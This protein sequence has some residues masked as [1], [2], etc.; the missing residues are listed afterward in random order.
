M[1]Q[2]EHRKRGAAKLLFFI[3]ALE[4]LPI[5]LPLHAVL[6]GVFFVEGFDA[7]VEALLFAQD[8]RFKTGLRKAS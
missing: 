2:F 4:R 6:A 3:S 1:T 8:G 7:A 5:S